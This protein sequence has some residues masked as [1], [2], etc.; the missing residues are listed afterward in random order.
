MLSTVACTG[1][2]SR[3]ARKSYSASRHSTQYARNTP[4]DRAR[5]TVSAYGAYFTFCRM[6]RACELWLFSRPT[7]SCAFLPTVHYPPSHVQ[8]TRTTSNSCR[9]TSS[10][11]RHCHWQWQPDSEVV[12]VLHDDHLLA[13]CSASGKLIIFKF[14]LYQLAGWKNLRWRSTM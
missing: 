2:R 10:T 1:V 6:Y 11:C 4:L 8:A 14:K 5:V 12:L 13:A 9:T 7:S 3:E